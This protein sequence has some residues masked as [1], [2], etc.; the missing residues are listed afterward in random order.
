VTVCVAISVRNGERFLAEAIESVLGQTHA[1]L[2]LRIYDN[3][4]TDGS[5]AIARSY[6]TDP[7]VSY[8]LNQADLG[9]YGSLNRALHETACELFVPFAADDVM[10]PQNLA[11]KV[12]AIEATGAG[13]A[14]SPVALIDDAGAVTGE[15]GRIPDRQAHYPAPAFFPRCAPVNPV[16]CPA[17][18]LRTAALRELGGFDGR[19]PYCADWHAWMRLALRHDVAFVDELLVCWRQHGDSGTSDSLRSA[20]YASEDPAALAAALDDPAFPAEWAAV[21][22]PFLAA[23]T[24][25]MATHLDRDGHRRVADGHAAYALALRALLLVPD[26]EGLRGLAA[27]LITGAGLTPPA[28]PFHTVF[29][30]HAEPAL[31]A[32]GVAIARALD[33]TGLLASFAVSIHPQELEAAVPLLEGLL[34]EGPD[35][36]ID[37]VPSAT[38]APL[39]VPGALV[40]AGW[41]SPEAALGE[42]YGLPVLPVAAPD[43][44][45]RP[46]D[47]NRF[48][49]LAAA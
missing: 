12:A 21:R 5:A 7:R 35:V 44:F 17:V 18:V 1:D 40:L 20:V 11:R 26:D 9:Y 23:C 30:A 8:C 3:L 25:R 19:I 13:F 42:R 45:A 33:Q 36:G 29:P 24:A 46:A 16:T 43:P 10:A 28:L 38:A 31:L 47:P 2:E 34:A 14:Y 15:L 27:G 4:S 41:A 6:L 39:L 32:E 22:G 48:E 49:T 37:L